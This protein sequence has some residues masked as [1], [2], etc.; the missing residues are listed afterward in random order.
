[1]K[2]PYTIWLL[3]TFLF[4]IT[5]HNA[6]GEQPVTGQGEW[7]YEIGGAEPISPSPNPNVTSMEIGGS[8]GLGFGG[9]CADL[10]PV[11]SVSNI[12][13]E[14]K[15]GIDQF[16]DAMVLAANS[17]IAAL[18]AIILQRANPGLY[19]HF[20]NAILAARARV[21]VAV[22]SC[23]QMVADNARGENPFKDWI[24]ISRAYSWNKELEEEGND[25]V[26]A[27]EDV[28]AANGD[29]GVPWLGGERGGADQDPIRVVYDTV[30]AGYN[31]TMNRE[32]NAE[33][34]PSVPDPPPRLFELWETPEQAAQ[35]AVEVLGDHIIR[36]CR[37]PACV[38][39]T[40]PGTGLPPKYEGEKE[41]IGPLLID[42][43]AGTTPPTL[44]N[45]REVS[46]PSLIVSRQLI[47]AIRATPDAQ[48]LAIIVGKLTGD[49]AS[50]RVV[51]RALVVRRLIL[52]GARVP[53]ISANEPATD[54]HR[55]VLLTIEREIDNFLFE[56]EIRKKLVSHTAMMVLEQE[57]NRRTRSLQHPG[58]PATDP[59]ALIRGRVDPE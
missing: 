51:E 59:D 48:E 45:L 47:E 37:D 26:S 31:V 23:E 29:A 34:A 46:A 9:A 56:S 40:E 39:S 33:G 3:A 18:P 28:E 16:E 27:K 43:V 25:P 12:L 5:S 41:V 53:E 21:D 38:P 35:W 58:T 4:G 49:I 7:Y 55:D 57:Q 36:T 44:E 1:M 24:R 32:P 2:R 42:L 11:L 22:K 14:I 52:T 10:D 20:Q 8:I 13:D 19:D 6:L 17:A 30:R 54:L 50:A 15:Q